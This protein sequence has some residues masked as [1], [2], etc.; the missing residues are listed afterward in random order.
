[1]KLIPRALLGFTAA[2]LVGAASLAASQ[3]PENGDKTLSPYFFVK[4]DDATLDALPLKE[5]TADAAIVGVIADV[6][7]RQTYK[8]TGQKALEAVYV[9]PGST[10]AAVY[11]MKMTIGERTILAQI[12]EREQARR[13]YEAAKQQG[14]SASLLEQQRPNVFQMNVANIM[15]GDEIQVE[16]KYTELLEPEEGVYQFTYPTVVGPRYS[17]KN[18]ETTPASEHW[19][20]SPYLHAGEAAPFTT[21]IKASIAAGLPIQEVVS[22]S[23]KVQVSFTDPARAE[24]TLDPAEQNPG[25][26]DYIL[27]YRLTGGQI[28]SG[29]LLSQG[30]SEKFFLAMLQ[31]PQRIAL[32]QIPARDYLFIVDVSGS[33]NGFPLE[34][35]KTLLRDLIGKLRP[36]DSF[37]VLL[38]AGGSSVLAEK[39][40]PATASNLAR[41]ISFIDGQ[42]G[43]GGTELLPALQRA[44]A[45][46]MR[47][48][49][50]RTIVIATDGYVD[51]EPEAFEL[52]RK[53]LG[54]ANVFPFGIGSSVNRHLIEGMAHVGLGEPFVVTNPAQ[55]PAQAAAFRRYIETP[56]LTNLKV[57]FQGFD[58]YDI[59]P[60]SLPDVFA[61]RPILIYG[62]WRGEAKG[63]I[64][65]SGRTGEKDYRA[66]LDVASVPAR[67][68]HEALRYLWARKRIALLGDFNA[69]RPSDERAKEITSLGL[70]YNLL[71]AY[72]SF[73]AIDSQVRNTSGD[74]TT[75]QQP[76][77]M[78]EGVSDLAI[79]GAP[80]MARS[81]SAPMAPML[82]YAATT[83][84]APLP[85]AADGSKADRQNYRSKEPAEESLVGTL[86]NAQVEAV[87]HA[88]RAALEA[89]Y[90]QAFPQG[91]RAA[92]VLVRFVVT[93]A[94]SVERIQIMQ[95]E[96]GS[97][98]AEQRLVQT[99]AA[100]RFGRQPGETRV[101]Y[102]LHFDTN[103]KLTFSAK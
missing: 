32:T 33:M 98:D 28:E 94:G 2:F 43:G 38:F 99:L 81:K 18:A 12:K 36:S 39:S 72:T 96:L 54:K 93:A 44:F 101:S 88:H 97:A 90:H 49:I 42:Q 66:Q 41:A 57:E 83:A 91:G 100:L 26:R 65:L 4:S 76:L 35:S 45:L 53:S 31:P 77:P 21:G 82:E 64:R 7:V 85:P 20:K 3:T 40:L 47:E 89:C 92:T 71:T 74:S 58:A 19:V 22:P 15:P 25:N 52:I 34:I 17:N 68:E 61:E 62:K 8:N 10:R 9:F 103:G 87:L 23:H 13:D 55:A 24:V 73:I 95:S 51:V 70:T 78:P 48:N 46:P 56:A 29:L 5:T 60:A 30:A 1:M 16:L 14:K 37:N 69:L 50:S 79:G 80:R 11:G 67:A 86:T 6:T 102:A 63:T 84:A 59:E 75:V 27:K